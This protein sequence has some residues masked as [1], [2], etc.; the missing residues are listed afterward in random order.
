MKIGI[1]LSSTPAYS[2]TFFNAKIKGLKER[3][4]EVILCVQSFDKAFNLCP[5]V[6]AP[7]VYKNNLIQIIA[8]ILVFI[9]LL[10]VHS[11][12]IS[13][14]IK[15]ERKHCT[16]YQLFK[17]IY[18]NSHILSQKLDYLH[19]GFAT[20][21]LEKEFIAKA[22]G[23]KMSVS[24]RGYDINIYPL[25]YPNCYEK[26]W[27]QVDKVHSISNYLLNKAFELGLSKEKPYKIITPAVQLND[28][29]SPISESDSKNIEMVT[30]ARLNWIKGLGIAIKTIDILV[31]KGFSVTYHIIGDGSKSDLEKYKFQ[32]YE[33]GLQDH[34]LF[35]GKL[36]HNKTLEL[37]KKESLYV[38]SSLNEGFCNALLEAQS[39][40]KLCIATNAGALPENIVNNET[41]W[42][43]PIDDAKSLALKIIEVNSLPLKD[44]KRVSLNSKRRIYKEFNLV[45]QIDNFI[46]FYN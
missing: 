20:I 2:E 41:G 12:T 34:I 1:V 25:K 5:V 29:Q 46:D 33:L 28:L 24:F 27:K 40:G 17:K 15:F 14:F 38:Q 26:L 4:L 44:K 30:I 8:T 36:S 9:K 21:A 23:A 16:W 32:V 19:F 7:K 35:H 18:L 3:G 37:L 39:L 10:V 31:Q 11:K 45:E 22:I 6:S 13:T 42:L 43:V